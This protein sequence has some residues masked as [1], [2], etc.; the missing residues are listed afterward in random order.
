MSDDEMTPGGGG[1]GIDMESNFPIDDEGMA[2]F[3]P[4]NVGEERDVT[5]AKDGG[6]MKK[7]LAPGEGFK[8]PEKGDEVTGAR[9]GAGGGPALRL[10]RKGLRE[11][12]LVCV[13]RVCATARA[14]GVVVCA[15]HYVGTLLNGTEFDS[16]RGRN[17]PF[18]F[19]LGMG[20]HTHART[21]ARTPTAAFVG[22][23]M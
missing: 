1:G 10:G 8:T 6:V 7:M 4:L 22:R 2:S 9:R 13:L 5:E 14:D 11:K 18:V 17:E 21:H 15:V 20:A 12:W 23:H 19:Q 3:A 16:S